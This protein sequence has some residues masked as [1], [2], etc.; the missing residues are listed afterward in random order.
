MPWPAGYRIN[1]CEDPLHD[2]VIAFFRDVP[3]ACVADC[4]GRSVG[5]I[6]LHAYHGNPRIRLC[7]SAVTV[8][9]R[10]G[11]NLMIHKAMLM[12]HPGDVIAVDGAGSVSQALVGELMR[13]TAIT[14][15]LGGFVIDGAVRDVADWADGRVPVY[16]RGHTPRGPSKDGPGEINVPIACAGLTI[17]PG[18]LLVGDGDGVVAIPRGELAE[19]RDRVAAHLQR[20]AEIRS[21]NAREGGDSA[22][23]DRLLRQK[24][25]PDLP[26]QPHSGQSGERA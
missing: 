26:Y 3:A 7:G 2:D 20:E 1:P 18:D 15:R 14:R 5:T 6:G 9:V 22:R 21:N 11:D 19:L 16:A 17:Y 12:A 13:T 23:I 24:G 25:L 10:P 8:R 4:M